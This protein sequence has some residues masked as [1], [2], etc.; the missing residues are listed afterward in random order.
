MHA[1][2]I[3]FHS[4]LPTSVLMKEQNPRVIVIIHEC[5]PK[6]LVPVFDVTLR[7]LVYA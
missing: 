1:Q 4:Q 5:Y 2:V 6:S 7:S 3:T